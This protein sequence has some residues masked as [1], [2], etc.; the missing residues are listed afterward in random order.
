LRIDPAS[1]RTLRIISLPHPPTG[2]AAGAGAIWVAQSNPG[3]NSVSLSAI[4]PLFDNPEPIRQVP[5]IVPGDG[6]ALAT[7]GASVWV[8]PGSGLLTQ[9]DSVTAAS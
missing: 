9:V 8:A 3:A 7:Q 2:L 1:L 6:A 4:D 5:T